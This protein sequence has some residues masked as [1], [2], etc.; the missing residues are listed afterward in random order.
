MEGA[1][2]LSLTAGAGYML[3][4]AL[5]FSAMSLMVRLVTAR[6]PSQEVVLARA[7]IT[8]VLSYALL[9]MAGISPWGKR[10]GWLF[11]RGLV[12]LAALSCFFAALSRLPFAEAS[13][14]HHT[15]P[16]W[17]ALFAAIFL[18]EALSSRVALATLLCMVGIVLVSK[19][20]SLFGAELSLPP[21]DVAVALG[22]A[23][24]SGLAYTIVRFLRTSET[25]LVIVFYFPLVSVPAVLP[26]VADDLLM[27]R[28]SEWLLLLGVG[29]A[30]Q[31]G[32]VFLT[33]AL[34]AG[35]AAPV[36]AISYSQ[37]VF[38]AVLGVIFLG[39]IP[40]G[41]TIAGAAIIMGALIPLSVRHSRQKP[42][43]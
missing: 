35:K 21:V 33:R 41:Y 12:G 25:P 30:T 39:E 32:Q 24:F 13:V 16:A 40:D 23:I 20:A 43:S 15:N 11:L 4:S 14:L 31:L 37:V 17:T 8:L 3:L 9:R 22:G 29:I 34:A 27:P 5:S 18:R 26:T 42:E 36:M 1:L 28:G 10:R 19:P 38:A 6:L 7:L 2:R